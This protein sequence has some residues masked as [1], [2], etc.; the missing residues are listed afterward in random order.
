MM[1]ARAATGDQSDVH[2]LHP[3]DSHEVV[4]V[5]GARHNKGHVEAVEHV[6]SI[7]RPAQAHRTLALSTRSPPMVLGPF[8][9]PKN[10]KASSGEPVLAKTPCALQP[11]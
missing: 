10:L 8:R 4:V 2:M 5:A 11:R 7:M 3:G 9:Q 1:S 6:G